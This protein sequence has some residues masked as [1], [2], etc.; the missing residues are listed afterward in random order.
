MKLL[1]DL[2]PVI[3]FFVS[4]K[5]A[6]MFPAQSN[7]LASQTLAGV[8][9]DGTL[10]ADQVPV[11]LATAVAI[12][13]TI[14]Q[15]G[16]LAARRRRIEPMLWM[17]LVV[18]VVFGGATI[19]FHDETFIKWKPTILYGLFAVALAA[20]RLI[21]NRNFI[22]SILGEQIAVPGPV[23]ERLLVLWV[24]FFV[25]MGVANL[26]VAYTVPTD[27]WVNFKL[28]GLFGMTLLFTLGVGL[29]L[30]R[31]I[32]PAGETVDG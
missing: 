5:I 6:G 21:W 8:V 15:V 10:P 22:R 18:I 16:W 7:A 29:Y 12:L 31:H 17:S 20:G 19:W 24:G 3:L 28:F 14:A 1:F 2:F 11:L 30:A 9:G 32:K 13:A 25:L 26:A 23:W 27:T 4:Y